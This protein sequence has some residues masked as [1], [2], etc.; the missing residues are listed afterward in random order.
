MRRAAV[1]AVAGLLAACGGGGGGG[2]GGP[3]P[4]QPGI[5]FTSA[6]SAGAESI[7]LQ[8][9]GATSA[10]VLVLRLEARETAGLY[11]VAFDLAYPAGLLRFDEVQ[12]GG[13]LSSGGAGTSFQFAEP[14]PGRLVI[15]LTRLADAPPAS[16]SGTLMT[17][18]FSVVAGGTG[19]FD[20]PAR[21]AYG[22]A[23]GAQAAQWLGGTV[24]VDR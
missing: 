7:S 5:T 2:G 14:A 18:R 15:G 19:S 12:E 21:Q 13:F 20:F 3:T 23:G 6:G 9:D 16:G 22:V 1:L 4:P 8:R 17:F 24:R 10:T 11:G